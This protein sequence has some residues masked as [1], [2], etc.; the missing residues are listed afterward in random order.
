MPDFSAPE[1]ASYVALCRELRLRR[2]FQEG[3]IVWVDLEDGPE[4]IGISIVSARDAETGVK[5]GADFTWLPQ[6]ADWLEML[7]ENGIAWMVLGRRRGSTHYRRRPDGSYDM[8]GKDSSG[9]VIRPSRGVGDP[10]AWEE[11]TGQYQTLEETAARLWMKV[12]GR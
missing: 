9:Y 11:E 7:Q 4:T 3:D 12:T 2:E 6:L 5:S 1:Y 8:V 10:D